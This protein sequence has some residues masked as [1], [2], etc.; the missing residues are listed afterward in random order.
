VLR[1]ETGWVGAV[2]LPPRDQRIVRGVDVVG[3]DVEAQV[4]LRGDH[5]LGGEGWG[6]GQGGHGA[7][8]QHQT[9]GKLSAHAGT[10]RRGGARGWERPGH[11]SSF[12]PVAFIE[13][14]E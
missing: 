12:R 11:E 3:A 6:G 10:V 8:E 2:V 5:A 9:G 14:P 13:R 7:P 4:R 1:P